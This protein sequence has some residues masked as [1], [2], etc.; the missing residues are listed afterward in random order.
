MFLSSQIHTLTS[1]EG[2]K[3]DSDEELNEVK[4]PTR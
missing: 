4:N 1:L 2:N 3:E